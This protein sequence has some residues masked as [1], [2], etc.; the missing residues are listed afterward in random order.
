MN[1]E[2]RALPAPYIIRTLPGTVLYYMILQFV[3]VFD[4]MPV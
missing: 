4:K 2:G 3:R 1:N